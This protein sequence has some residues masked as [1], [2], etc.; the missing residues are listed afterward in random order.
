MR[1]KL[2]MLAVMFT[3]LCLPCSAWAAVEDHETALMSPEQ[4]YQYEYVPEVMEVESAPVVRALPE[5]ATATDYVND[6]LDSFN[7]VP[8]GASGSPTSLLNSVRTLLGV[9]ASGL[10]GSFRSMLLLV[11]VGIVFMWWGVRKVIRVLFAAFKN[12]RIS[13]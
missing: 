2:M 3:M 7:V 9:T 13:V 10:S 8:M 6:T 5:D 12:R 4:L 1:G 11:A